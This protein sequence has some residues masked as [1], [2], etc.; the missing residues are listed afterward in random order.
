MVTA[1]CKDPVFTS[2]H[3]PGS[4]AQ[5][6]LQQLTGC[7]ID[8]GHDDLGQYAWQT[9]LIDGSCNL[10]VITAY[11]VTQDNVN[12]C[13][14]I[15]SAMQQWRKLKKSASLENPNPCQ[16]T[17]TDLGSFV[18]NHVTNGNEVLIMIDVNSPSGDAVITMFLD[19]CGL[20]DLM[21]DYLPDHQPTT[22]QRGH[23]KIDHIW[24]TP[25][26]L[27]A[28]QHAGVIPFSV[29]PNSTHAILFLDLSFEHLSGISSQ[30]LYDSTHPRFHNLW[31]TDIKAA[32]QYLTFVQQ[33]FYAENIHH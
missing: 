18:Q 5:F 14:Y 26:V 7:I 29:G 21:H 28:T 1:H 4:V 13:G 19:N 27:T 16:Q 3:Q 11:H 6:V 24:G 17:L 15:M 33:G 23:F 8:H 10:V 31:L 2:P 32:E 20:F 22:Y 30:S 12:N 25:G 9:L